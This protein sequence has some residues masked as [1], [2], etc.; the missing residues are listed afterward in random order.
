MLPYVF[1]TLKQ[2]KK[3][4][5]ADFS[6]QIMRLKEDVLICNKIGQKSTIIKN[7]SELSEPGHTKVLNEY[8]HLPLSVP[9]AWTQLGN[10]YALL[11][12]ESETPPFDFFFRKPTQ[13]AR[14]KLGS[15]KCRCKHPYN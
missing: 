12:W 13:K 9:F 10:N 2:L 14:G 3:K 11:M 5:K 8:L 1:S 4:K 6:S 15:S 7:I